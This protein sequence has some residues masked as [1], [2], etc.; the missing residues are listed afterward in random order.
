MKTLGLCLFAALA[1]TA[2]ATANFSE[3]KL[4]SAMASAAKSGK[5]VA[6][7]FYQDY[8]LPNCPTCVSSTDAAN[9]ALKSAIPRTDV[10]VIEVEADDRDLDKLP[11]SIPAQGRAPRIV[12]TDVGCEEVIAKLDGAPDRDQAKEFKTTVSEARSGS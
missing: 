3:R 9:K 4:A 6:F 2:T 5:L 7:V 12:V 8:A 1:C 10:V 11:S